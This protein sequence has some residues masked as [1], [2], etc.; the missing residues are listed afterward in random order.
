MQQRVM[1]LAMYNDSPEER[2]TNQMSDHLIHAIE[3]V[4]EVPRHLCHDRNCRRLGNL[5]LVGLIL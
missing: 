4:L 2:L 5:F 1:K 3:G